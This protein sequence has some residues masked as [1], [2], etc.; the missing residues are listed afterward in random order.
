MT[1]LWNNILHMHTDKSFTI[2][3]L[4]SH[5]QS[6]A[7]F[8]FQIFIW[9]LQTEKQRQWYR[10]YNREEALQSAGWLPQIPTAHLGWAG[11]KAEKQQFTPDL[12]HEQ[13]KPSTWAIT[14]LPGTRTAGNYTWKWNP[15]TPTWDQSVLSIKLN[16]WTRFFPPLCLLFI[17]LLILV[18]TFQVLNDLSKGNHE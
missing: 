11:S 10:V 8:F 14:C 12:P 13:Q 2:H 9:E 18:S 1:S 16:S 4:P 6:L 5:Y 7:F 15:G 3:N 17:C